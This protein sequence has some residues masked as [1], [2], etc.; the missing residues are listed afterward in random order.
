MS[1][2]PQA[3]ERGLLP[4]LLALT[5]LGAVLRIAGLEA[6]SLSNDELAS[7]SQSQAGTW[8]DVVH[9]MR[10]NVHPPG[11]VLLVR[12]VD[13]WLGSSPAAL[14]LPSAIAGALSIP[15]LFLLS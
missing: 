15:A 3:D 5:L 13:A 10:G 11:W 9:R 1:Q 4:A 14:R 12:A 2:A 8:C 6:E 7:W